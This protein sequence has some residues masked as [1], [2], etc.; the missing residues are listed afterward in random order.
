MIQEQFCDRPC[1]AL[2]ADMVKSREV[3]AFQRPHVQ[4]SFLAFVNA[5]NAK[6]QAALL[7]K[8]VITLG[9]EFQG[10]LSSAICIPDLMW[11][12]EEN[13]SYRELRVGIGFGVIH[14]SIPEIAINV[15]GPALHNAR[16]AIETAKS[17]RTLGGMFVGF[18]DL[19]GVLNGLA[20]ILC[21][22]RSKFSRSQIRT[23]KLLREGL[24]QT[25]VAERLQVSRQAISKQVSFSGWIP[26]I[27]AEDAWRIIFRKYVDPQIGA[28]DDRPEPDHQ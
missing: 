8:F 12:I 6:Y 20:R 27:E 24:R 11:D 9:D 25:E 4:Q 3:P 15:D 21:F 23:F 28:R 13:F 18:G 26:Y 14:T 10:L 16:T 5:L 2:I 1:I 7:S 19:D 17:K 22:H